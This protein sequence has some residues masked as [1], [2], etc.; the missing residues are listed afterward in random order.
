MSWSDVDS[1]DD[2]GWICFYHEF[3]Q[4]NAP[5][6]RMWRI[7]RFWNCC[8]TFQMCKLAYVVQS[9][10]SESLMLEMHRKRR[11][12]QSA[13]RDTKQDELERKRLIRKV[14]A[15]EQELKLVGRERRLKR[16][17]HA[18]LAWE[19]PSVQTNWSIDTSK[20][21]LFPKDNEQSKAEPTE[22]APLMD[23]SAPTTVET[24][25]EWLSEQ[26]RL[27]L[28]AQRSLDAYFDMVIDEVVRALVNLL[29]IAP[30]KPALWFVMYLRHP[31]DS[32]NHTQTLSPESP[33]AERR[34]S[35]VALLAASPMLFKTNFELT[36]K[37]DEIKKA[38]SEMH[39]RL[40][41]MQQILAELEQ[42]L[43]TRNRFIVKLSE[44]HV[45]TRTQAIMDGTP[46]F[47]N[48][49]KHWVLP[50]FLLDPRTLSVAQLQGLRRAE[51][52][53]MEEDEIRWEFLL[54]AQLEYDS[55]T[56]IQSMWR[57]RRAYH[58]F[59]DLVSRRRRAATLIQRNYFHYLFT[60]AISLPRWCRPGREVIVAP[61]IAQKCAISFQ[62]YPKRDFPAGNY[63]REPKG[64]SVMELMEIAR[65]DETCAGFT[66]D[67]A[68]KRFLP[69]LLSQL[70]PMVTPPKRKIDNESD[71][72]DTESDNEDALTA[73]DGL[74]VKVFPKKDEKLVN[75]AI[76]VEVPDDHFGLVRVVL[77][78]IAIT[79]LVPVTKLTD[80]WKRIRVKRVKPKQ[81]RKTRAIVFAKGAPSIYSD[82]NENDSPIVEP[83]TPDTTYERIM[84]EEEEVEESIEKEWRRQRRLLR[85][86]QHSQEGAN[87]DDAP[88]Y[89]FE[90]L[91]TG[92]IMRHGH[93]N[94][95]H[96]DPGIRAHVIATR[97]KEYEDEKNRQFE[98]NKVLSAIKIQ[99]A[100][101]CKR[102]REHFHQMLVLRA[103]ERE[104]ERL[105]D[106]VSAANAHK[107]KAKPKKGGKSFFSK[108]R[109]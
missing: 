2:N 105:V 77:D 29:L 32:T 98:A 38:Q 14:I 17:D 90:D 96:A 89:I 100:W 73:E 48:S 106:Q 12:I 53:L 34:K 45:T 24:E 71:D 35:S 8:N 94:N 56:L 37:L 92:R 91:V 61:S 30:E 7:P 54:R 83:G 93:P 1:E 108:W 13:L 25:S 9:T 39:A 99:C 70:K 66:T 23:K 3:T 101:R 27:D 88:D 26:L 76:V 65:Q 58:A 43:A 19:Q 62:F 21:P 84:S 18:F 46:V 10:V 87:E 72:E 97:K 20:V 4:L 63:R 44:S 95:T 59:Q 41:A 102:A 78:G 6:L 16:A 31:V 85:K 75:S 60:R 81:R 33:P 15:L 68:F 103:K 69:R 51:C 28:Q 36:R 86:R 5:T 104:H 52:F 50:G 82:D 79:E 49:Q 22:P 74:Y 11:V 107:R 42:E 57:G 80:R 47:L 64:T 55:A 67:G 109:G 40:Q